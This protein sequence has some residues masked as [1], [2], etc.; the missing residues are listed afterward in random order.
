VNTR[1][2]R[3]TGAKYKPDLLEIVMGYRRASEG[4]S[5]KVAVSAELRPLLHE[6]PRVALN[7]E[8]DWIHDNL[9]EFPPIPS[10]CFAARFGHGVAE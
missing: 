9:R 3:F 6:R 2:G 7:I 5:A 4:L 10:T 8:I 1:G